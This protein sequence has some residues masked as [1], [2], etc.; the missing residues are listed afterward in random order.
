VGAKRSFPFAMTA[1]RF[2]VQSGSEP[3]GQELEH[4]A[5]ISLDRTNM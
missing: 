4:A 2:A 5:R 1:S 3:K